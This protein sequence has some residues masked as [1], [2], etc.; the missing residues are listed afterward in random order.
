MGV[1]C[2]LAT[3]RQAPQARGCGRDVMIRSIEMVFFLSGTGS[4]THLR[5]FCDSENHRV[6]DWLGNLTSIEMP[7]QLT[8][9]IYH[10]L[11]RAALRKA[12]C[13]EI[14][15][16]I[17]AVER[18][19]RATTQRPTRS[20]FPLCPWYRVSA[21]ADDAESEGEIPGRE[22][23]QLGALDNGSPYHVDAGRRWGPGLPYFVASLIA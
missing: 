3:E 15:L 2:H 8:A 13:P 9:E 12:P 18:L 1:R 19:Q 6:A 10:G 16:I 7:T 17:V 23:W 5:V 14:M 11:G 4:A 22:R 20:D 21:G